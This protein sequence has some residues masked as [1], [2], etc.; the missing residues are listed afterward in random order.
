[1][2]YTLLASIALLSLSVVLCTSCLYIINHFQEFL[3]DGLDQLNEAEKIEKASDRII[4][5]YQKR[6]YRYLGSLYALYG[7]IGFLFVSAAS[8][9]RA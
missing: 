6:L 9:L 4:T 1:M 8:Y 2:S 7:G 5:I 3:F